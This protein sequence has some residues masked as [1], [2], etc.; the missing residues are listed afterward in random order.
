MKR[1]DATGVAGGT[2]F[3]TV[4]ETIDRLA[5]SLRRSVVLD[6]PDFTLLACSAHYG[7][8]DDARLASLIDRHPNEDQLAHLREQRL[9][10]RHAPVILSAAASLGF[11]FDR[12]C[13]PLRSRFG[14]LGYLWIT[15]RAPLLPGEW[16]M[17]IDAASVFAHLIYNT[18]QSIVA[19]N[20]EVESEMLG[21]LAETHADRVRAGDELRDL[22]MFNRSRRFVALCLSFSQEWSPWDGPAPRD[23][24]TQVLIRAI[25]TP[26]IDSYS[27]VPTTPD[28]F[29]LIGF[30]NHPTRDALA[31][32]TEGIAHQLGKAGIEPGDGAAIGVGEA[33]DALYD[34]WMSFDQAAVA[35][36]VAR[37]TGQRSVYWHDE[38]AAVA[39]AALL[40]EPTPP[41]LMPAIIGVLAASPPETLALFESYFR[42]GGNAAL[43]AEELSI[44]RATVYYRL[45]RFREESGFD[46]DDPTSRFAVQA[47]LQ[48]RYLRPRPH[49]G[50]PWPGSL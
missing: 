5:S 27:F 12:V 50:G 42:H 36:R 20:A 16:I 9:N 14:I 31:S 3:D 17:I 25:T 15:L 22:G 35:A 48:Q 23:A 43:I 19:V 40:A 4:Q 49:E 13:V 21:L 46:F 32:V 7:D 26:M 34:S 33:V 39:T 41:H 11:E 28:T 2:V 1:G 29:I 24:I 47:W 6:G 38:P 45:R 18:E 30:Q 10:M 8:V 37:A 44:H